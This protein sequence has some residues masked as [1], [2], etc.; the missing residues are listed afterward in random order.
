MTQLASDLNSKTVKYKQ[1]SAA[2]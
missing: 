1:S 2:L